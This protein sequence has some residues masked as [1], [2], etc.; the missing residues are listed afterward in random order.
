MKGLLY[1]RCTKLAPGPFKQFRHCLQFQGP[2]SPGVRGYQYLLQECPPE[3]LAGGEHPG[4][5]SRRRR[6]KR[7]RRH[8]PST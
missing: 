8:S 6:W 4:W 7:A 5:V 2:Q 1:W 3:A